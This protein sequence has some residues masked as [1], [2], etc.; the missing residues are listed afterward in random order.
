MILYL[1]VRIIPTC[2]SPSPTNNISPSVKKEA[3]EK[4]GS[5]ELE[6][7]L[8]TSDCSSIS[9]LLLKTQ[10]RP[11]PRYLKTKMVLERKKCLRG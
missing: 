2:C 8:G 6:P 4:D 7:Q 10:P 3:E 1:K 9:T 11:E 5:S